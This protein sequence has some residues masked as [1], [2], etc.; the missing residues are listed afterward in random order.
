MAY[1]DPIIAYCRER[2]L[3]LDRDLYIAACFPQGPPEPWP[4]ELEA[5]MPPEFQLTRKS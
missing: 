4:A 1:V 2:G 3:N 5:E